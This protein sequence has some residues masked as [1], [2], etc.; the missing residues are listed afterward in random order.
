M[1]SLL[2][3]LAAS[4]G[5]VPL[6][7]QATVRLSAGATYSSAL[8]DD[9]VL[10]TKL[11]PAIAPTVSVAVSYPTGKGPYRVLIEGSFA[12][13]PLNVTDNAGDH[14]QLAAVASVTALVL[15]EGPIRGSLHWQA[16]GGAI[17]YRP[18]QD[19]GIFQDGGARRWLLA[20]GLVWLHPL[21]ARM[22]LLVTG[23]V[24]TQEFTTG[25]LQALG[26]G[27]EQSVQRFALLIGVNRRW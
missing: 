12:R 25:T 1:R 5:V 20:G 24:D 23:R 14:D 3:L 27:S 8:V 13:A 15:A 4:L 17:F 26:Y 6:A 16:G 21:T 9:G 18:S 10:T 22:D 19:Q 2:V 11:R 7:A